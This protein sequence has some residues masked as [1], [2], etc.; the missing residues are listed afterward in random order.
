[1]AKPI[2]VH[3]VDML[4]YLPLFLA[5]QEDEDLR[6][7]FSVELAPAPY[8]DTTAFERLL[9]NLHSDRNVDFCLCD[10]MVVN[11]VN[12]H[13]DADR[14]VAIAQ[15]VQKIPFWA[16]DHKG[17]HF[18]KETDFASCP[19]LFAYPEGTTGFVLGKMIERQCKGL[20]NS[21]LTMRE[22]PIG[23]DLS[24]SLSGEGAVVLEADI[25]LI[26]KYQEDTR[27]EIVFSFPLQRRYSNF[28]FTALLTRRGVL[29]SPGGRARARQL[30]D[31]LM[32][33]IHTIYKYPNRAFDVAK[34]H[35]GPQGYNDEII[36]GALQTLR[37]QHI[38]SRSLVIGRRAW[39][40]SIHLRRSVDK[41]FDPPSFRNFVDNSVSQEAFLE[42][43]DNI[44]DRKTFFLVRNFFDMPL[45]RGTFEVLVSG[46]LLALPLIVTQSLKIFTGE[47]LGFVVIHLLATLLM[48]LLYFFRSQIRLRLHLDP[49][50]WYKEVILLVL[51]YSIEEY[52]VLVKLM[53]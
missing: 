5:F 49:A 47:K 39:D 51:G 42:H 14:P 10:P 31:A 29:R 36:Y 28:C 18:E 37:E 23:A 4:H 40:E 35:F 24:L 22:K 26:R 43:L 44:V 13:K 6:E 30:V 32:N 1:M 33:A 45:I 9:S 38:F 3:A 53:R 48:I 19:Q 41:H 15:I 12:F 46:T 2:I 27:N 17:P 8:G 25:L 11:L 20:K 16:V 50:H 7:S 21:R 34:Q 52:A